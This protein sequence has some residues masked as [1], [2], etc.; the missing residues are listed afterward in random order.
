MRVVPIFLVLFFL[1]NCLI[2]GQSVLVSQSSPSGK[3][4]TLKLGSP[5]EAKVNTPSLPVIWKEFLPPWRLE[6]QN[7]DGVYDYAIRR[8]KKL[9]NEAEAYDFN[10]DGTFDDYYIYEDG[11]LIRREVDS[12]F[13]GKIDLW[14]YLKNGSYIRGYEKDSNFDGILDKVKLY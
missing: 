4:G 7:G 6:D 1:T 10:Y 13:D 2:F 11:V 8:D 12:N 14:V 9:R 3:D 5:G